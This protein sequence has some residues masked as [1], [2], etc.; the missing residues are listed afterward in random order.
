MRLATDHGTLLIYASPVA[1]PR[2][3]TTSTRHQ[4]IFVTH[5]SIQSRRFA[6]FYR[7]LSENAK[8]ALS[9]S[10]YSFPFNILHSSLVTG[11]GVSPPIPN[12]TLKFSWITQICHRAQHSSPWERQADKKPMVLISSFIFY[13]LPN[14][15][16]SRCGRRL[17]QVNPAKNICRLRPQI[18]CIYRGLCS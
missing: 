10:R 1:I 11:R 18:C 13:T 17:L 7:F 5:H 15:L 9:S 3:V 4:S 16:A 14:I 8:N 6:L 2:A 12:Q